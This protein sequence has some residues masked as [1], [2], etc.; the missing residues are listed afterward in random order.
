M[1]GDGTGFRVV[2]STGAKSHASWSAAWARDGRSIFC[3]DLENIYRMGLDGVTIQKW[4]LH[5]LLHEA[6]LNSGAR[7]AVSPDGAQLLMDVD[8]AEEHGRKNWD[9]PAPA[10]WVMDVAAG[11]AR[12]LSLPFCWEPYWISADDIAFISQGAN[13]KEPSIYRMSADGKGQKLLV[14][15]ARR[16]SVSR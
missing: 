6:D 4:A 14:S 12:K 1:N 8:L 13:E 9:G 11:K 15:H 16:P 10:I 3:Q 2:K 5:D 7:F